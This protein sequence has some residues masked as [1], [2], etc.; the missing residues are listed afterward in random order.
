[1]RATVATDGAYCVTYPRNSTDEIDAENPADLIS[2]ETLI[3]HLQ[4]IQKFE[5]ERK[6]A[7]ERLTDAK[8]EA[9]EAGIDGQALSLIQRLS[10]MDEEERGGFLF[11]I[12][13]YAAL[14]RYS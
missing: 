9:A 6:Q 12:N 3:H 4:R 5:N 1:M 2:A 14:L 13:K 11:L 7:S 8:K 10:K